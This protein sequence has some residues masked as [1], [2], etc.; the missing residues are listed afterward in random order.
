ME[1]VSPGPKEQRYEQ[2]ARKVELV[3]LVLTVVFV[4]VAIVGEFGWVSADVQRWL[5]RVEWVLWIAFPVEFGVMWYLA[6]DRQ[7][8]RRERW[9]ELPIIVVTVPA[10]VTFL[11]WLAPLR[12]LRFL[13]SAR[14]LR[15]VR[16]TRV[17]GLLARY[18]RGIRVVLTRHGLHYVLLGSV[19][20]YCICVAFVFAVERGEG[21]PIQSYG[22]AL[23]WGITAITNLPNDGNTPVT[24]AGKGLAVA[25]VFLG[26]TVVSLITANI[27][28]FLVR[29][30]ATAD[31]ARLDQSSEQLERIERRFPDGDPK[32]ALP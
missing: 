16:L 27:A 9:W 24:T 21:R 7:K 15:A 22:E 17:G 25:I 11:A 26:L 18:T 20:L 5:T 19:V 4:A 14:M 31:A 2:L 28:A 3:M 23:W 12:F 10:L 13:R 32:D 1:D 29:A 8:F 30:E 6:P